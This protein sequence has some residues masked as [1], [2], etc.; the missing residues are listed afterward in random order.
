[1]SSYCLM[2]QSTDRPV[3]PLR[4]DAGDL[5]IRDNR[6]PLNGL[7]RYRRTPSTNA[8]EFAGACHLR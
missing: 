5:V 6:C 8:T 2:M 7:R 4:R 1:M 3:V